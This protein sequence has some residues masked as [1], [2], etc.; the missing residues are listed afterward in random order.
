MPLSRAD[1]LRRGGAGA[2]VLV[3]PL[4]LAPSAA[5]AAALSDND[6]AYARLLVTAEL[7]ALDFYGRA[8]RSGHFAA[9]AA[10][11]LAR[12]RADERKHHRAV[13]RILLDAGLT[14][15]DPGD[16]DFVYPRRAFTSHASSATLG[17][18]LE[19]LF[20]SACLGAVEGLDAPELKTLAGRIA[21]SEAQ[22]LSVFAGE[23]RGQRIGAAF[24]RPWTIDRASDALDYFTA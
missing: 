3:A 14:P 15:P 13:A 12:A 8:L 18:R 19:S 16:I 6:L 9:P 24:P 4:A 11:E 22:H 17:A 21:A 20:L 1:L 10:R 23:A 7:L 5:T 2:A